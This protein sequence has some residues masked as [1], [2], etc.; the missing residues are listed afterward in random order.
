M[1]PSEL[2]FQSLSGGW[3][4]AE[5]MLSA[6]MKFHIKRQQQDQHFEQ[7]L[8]VGVKMSSEIP[9]I[10]PSYVSVT[11]LFVCPHILY[12]DMHSLTVR[13]TNC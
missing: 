6:N 2:K 9:P 13:L 1:K 10:I 5:T 7:Q 12:A 4:I 11:I 3:L 8:L